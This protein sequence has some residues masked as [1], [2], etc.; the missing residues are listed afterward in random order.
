M[1]K[2][3]MD[4]YM[5]WTNAID[6]LKLAHRKDLL[7]KDMIIQDLEKEIQQLKKRRECYVCGCQDEPLKEFGD[8]M[9]SFTG[10]PSYFFCA[11][12]MKCLHTY[13]D[14]LEGLDK[15]L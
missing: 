10:F 3:I 9:R 5:N 1:F 2:S 12:K 8:K 11:E 7:T 4:W 6:A 14:Q 15:A 13:M